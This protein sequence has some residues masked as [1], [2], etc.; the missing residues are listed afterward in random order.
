MAGNDVITREEFVQTHYTCSAPHVTDEHLLA[1]GRYFN[2]NGM[3][4]AI[5]ACV[6]F[7]LRGK[8]RNWSAYW[9]AADPDYSKIEAAQKVAKHG[10]KMSQSDAKHFFPRLD[11]TYWR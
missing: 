8:L 1:I 9:G 3:V 7:G 6:A 11:G 5:V 4:V 2:G 10:D